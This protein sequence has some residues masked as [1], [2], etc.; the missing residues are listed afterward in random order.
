MNY[1]EAVQQVI[2]VIKAD[3]RIVQPWRNKA[4][5]RMEEAQ[6]FVRMGLSTTYEQPSEPVC[7]CPDGGI[8]RRC[9]VHGIERPL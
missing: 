8:A 6:A 3:K 7:T 5:A 9:P 2:A 4:V 1:D